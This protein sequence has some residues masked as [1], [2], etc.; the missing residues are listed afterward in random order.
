MLVLIKVFVSIKLSLREKYPHSKF[1]WSVF[2]PNAGKYGPEELRIRT[3]FTQYLSLYYL[4]KN[5]LLSVVEFP[6]C[7]QESVKIKKKWNT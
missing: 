4:K 1:F 2:N 3:L 7:D 5:D 6:Y